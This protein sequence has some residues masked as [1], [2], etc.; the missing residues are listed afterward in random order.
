[1]PPRPLP[2][3]NRVVLGRGRDLTNSFSFFIYLNKVIIIYRYIFCGFRILNIL[4]VLNFVIFIWQ[5]TTLI[6][7]DLFESPKFCIFV[8]NCKKFQTLVPANIS[9]LK[10]CYISLAT[11]LMYTWWQIQGVSSSHQE[12]PT[13]YPHVKP[14]LEA[15]CRELLRH[16]PP[17][18]QDLELPNPARDL[19]LFTHIML[20]IDWIEDI[21]VQVFC[22]NFQSRTHS[23]VVTSPLLSCTPSEREAITK[24]DGPNGLNYSIK[25]QLSL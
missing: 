20:G 21:Q 22:I 23:K 4:L 25:C 11:M 13:L 10:V 8:Q 15:K 16:V 17:Q 19:D 12:A 1:M 7:I 14:A 6:I 5:L 18:L 9:Y 3:P 24:K 2:T